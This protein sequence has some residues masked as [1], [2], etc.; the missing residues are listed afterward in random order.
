[1]NRPQSSESGSPSEA[2]VSVVLPVYNEAE[3][4]PELAARVIEALSGCTRNY[5]II[6]VND[7]SADRSPRV[8][9]ALAARIR[10][11]RVIHFTR[12]FG[13]Q[14]AV[15]AGLARARGHAVILMD[16]DMQDAPHAIPRFVEKWR[17]GYDVVYAIRNQRK[18]NLLKRFSFAAFHRLLAR[19]ASIH[20]PSDAGIFGLIDRRVAAEICAM[21][22]RDRYFPGLRS[23]VGLRQTG[24]EVERN[25]RYDKHARVSICG[26][27]RLAK[28]AI[29]SF[30]S[31]PLTV[32]YTIGALAGMVFVGL[33]GFSLF[34]KLFTDQAIPGWTSHILTGSFFGALNALGISV[35]G[36]YVIR[37]YDQVRG[38]PLYLVD[39]TVN[40][41]S[42]HDVPTDDLEGDL[43]YV[44][45]LRQLAA[46]S[47]AEGRNPT[48]QPTAV[49]SVPD[50]P[51]PPTR[52]P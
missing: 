34:C 17:A 9:D 15:Q 18:E 33:A 14:A 24:I 21:G 46:E 4:L 30:S 3:V 28:T 8:L 39:R 16:S 36:E 52:L 10:S 6:F 13:H 35:L 42:D 7:G 23:W 5:E 40:F 43:P 26:L 31:F 2:M 51:S 37:I 45:L 44:D 50:R 27:F 19:M 1:M 49:P 32:F 11:V 20:I 29:F 41:L 12:N 22:E 25:A 47:A 48:G 38:R